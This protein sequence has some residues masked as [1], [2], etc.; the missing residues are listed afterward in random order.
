MKKQHGSAN[1]RYCARA[2]THYSTFG[3]TL[4]LTLKPNPNPQAPRNP[5]QRT[6][7]RVNLT[8]DSIM[9]ANPDPRGPGKLQLACAA[10]VFVG[11]VPLRV[12]IF[13]AFSTVSNLVHIVEGRVTAPQACVTS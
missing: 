10:A 7:T 12:K 1:K 2:P 3:L 9:C 11:H 13:Y 8:L 6:Q 4:T 5:Q